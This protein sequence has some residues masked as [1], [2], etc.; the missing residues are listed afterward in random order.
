M[1][2]RIGRAGAISLTVVITLGVVAL[3]F[4]LGYRVADAGNG[5]DL[6]GIQEVLRGCGVAAIILAAAAFVGDRLSRRSDPV[7]RR[8]V[9]S[10]LGWVVLAPAVLWTTF[11]AM[12]IGGGGSDDWS[13][14]DALPD[15]AIFAVPL[16]VA[17]GMLFLLARRPRH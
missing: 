4:W 8:R 2:S 6:L 17:S 13:L 9:A 15:W 7:L 14:D 12:F 1:E 16:F 10:S 11:V 3:A 5:D